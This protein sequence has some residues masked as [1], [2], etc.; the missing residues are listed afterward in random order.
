[1]SDNQF[2]SGVFSLLTPHLWVITGMV[3]ACLWNLFF[4]KRKH[5]TPLVCIGTLALAAI[6]YLKQFGVEQQDLFARLYVID[7][8]SI[9]IGLITCLVGIIVVFMSMGYERKFTPNRGEYYAILMTAILSVMF[10]AGTADLIMLF[11]ALE[12]LTICCVLLSGIA[13]RDLKSNEASLKYLLS[14]A[15][16]TAT[17][18]YGMSFLYGLTGSTNYYDIQA[19]IFQV[20]QSPSLVAI[21]LIVLLISVVGFKLS[22]VPFHMW[23]PDVYEGAPTP[24]TAFLSVGSKLGGLVVAL[25]LLSFT[26]VSAS[27]DWVPV[28]AGLAILSMV[29]GNLIALCQTSV[30]RMLAYSSIAHVGYFLIAFAAN[31]GQSLSSLL[32]Y[33]IIY[34]FMNLGAFACAIMIENELGTD[35]MTEWSGLI[36]KRPWLTMAMAICLMNLAGLPV[37]PAGFLAKFFVFWSGIQMYSTLGN[38]LVIVALVTSVPAVFYYVRVAIKMIVREPSV[39]VAALPNRRVEVADSQFGPILAIA[40]CL[41]GIIGG[42]IA[43]NPLMEFSSKA[44][45]SLSTGPVV[46][47]TPGAAEHLQ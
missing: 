20:A 23:T 40:I 30:K 47:S 6:T 8:L 15:A 26:F 3:I 36:R 24:V 14:T 7:T 9:A 21:L 42:S 4:P 37:P 17:F 35:D 39:K 29:V 33:V 18:M 38:W 46:G 27:A 45:S 5:V 1:M 11:V 44:V 32:F 10:L 28:I 12:T 31:N 22:M 41:V 16:T 25:R 34:G 2:F 13:K 43:V 19:K